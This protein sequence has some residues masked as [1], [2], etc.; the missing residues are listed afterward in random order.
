MIF[1]AEIHLAFW[2]VKFHAFHRIDQ[3]FGIGGLGFAQCGVD[4]T[5][6]GKTSGGKEIWRCLKAFG[7]LSN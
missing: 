1:F 4:S 2:R 5:S 3:F 6:C 7:V